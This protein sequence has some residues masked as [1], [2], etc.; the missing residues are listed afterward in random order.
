[1][2]IAAAAAILVHDRRLDIVDAIR[3]PRRE[4]IAILSRPQIMIPNCCDIH[5]KVDIAGGVHI[6]VAVLHVGRDRARDP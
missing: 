3:H 1:M 2:S 6:E 5:S 4:V